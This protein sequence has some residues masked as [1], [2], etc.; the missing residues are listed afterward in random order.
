MWHHLE[1]LFCKLRFTVSSNWSL[2][3]WTGSNIILC[4]WRSSPEKSKFSISA[5]PKAQFNDVGIGV[6][7]SNL[8]KQTKKQTKDSMEI[9]CCLFS[10]WLDVLLLLYTR[11]FNV[12][13]RNITAIGGECVKCRRGCTPN[14]LCV[15][16]LK[17]SSISSPSL[18][19]TRHFCGFCHPAKETG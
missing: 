13:V 10:T 6:S 19:M 16:C 18:Q 1:L 8:N 11:K 3:G 14:P 12:I 2:Q 4:F 17:I 9:S 5:W 15:G 7:A